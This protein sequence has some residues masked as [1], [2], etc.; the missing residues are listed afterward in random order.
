M[1][2]ADGRSERLGRSELPCAIIGIRLF[3]LGLG[4][5]DEKASRDDGL[6]QWSAGVQ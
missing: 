1:S 2:L 3:D 4:I 6:M 5:H